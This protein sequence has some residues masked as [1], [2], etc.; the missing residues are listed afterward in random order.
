[1]ELLVVTLAHTSPGKDA[2][3]LARVRL[4]ADTIRNAPGLMNAR[5]Y[6]SREKDA[7]Y[8]LLTTWENEEFWQKA[9]ARYSP[10]NLLQGSDKA[11]LI[12]PPEQW[13]MRYLWGYSRP[14]AQ[15]NIAAAHV[16]T[17]RSDQADRIER[18]WVESLRRQAMEPTLAFAFL[19]RG[20]SEDALPHSSPKTNTLLSGR[21]GNSDSPAFLQTTFL[22]IL[23]WPTETHR[24]DFYADQNY[25]AINTV[26]SSMG[27]VRILA[28]DPL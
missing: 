4:I 28:L 20:D 16:A 25:K 12:A 11:L 7:Y 24:Y 27:T 15:P 10:R 2:E 3:G 13:L 17:I 5:F 26:L 8:F 21:N 22:N 23:S 6:R 18:G 14:S 9:Q 19:A 1:M